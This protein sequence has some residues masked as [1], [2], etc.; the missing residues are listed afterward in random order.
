MA[1]TVPEFFDPRVLKVWDVVG[2][3]PRGTAGSGGFACLS[4]KEL[5]AIYAA[6]PSP[7]SAAETKRNASLATE[8]ART[9]LRRG[10]ELARHMSSDEVARD[11]D[12]LRDAVG[13]ERLNYYGVSYGTLIGARYAEHFPTRVGLMVLDSAVRPDPVDEQDLTQNEVDAYA[14]GD[15]YS[16]D[17]AV[18]DFAES[19]R[20][21]VTCPLGADADAVASSITR[22]L[23]GLSSTPLP[24][25]E[26]SLPRLTEGWAVSAI[27]AGLRDKTLWPD[28]VDAL[29]LAID[30]HDGTELVWMAMDAVGRDDDGTYPEGPV[31]NVFLPVICAD[32][33]VTK[34]DTMRPSPDV[35]SNHPLWARLSLQNFLPCGDWSGPVRPATQYSVDLP[36]PVL[37]IGNQDD[38]TTPIE[39]TE[40]LADLIGGSR[41]VTVEADGH[42][43]YAAGNDC[44][45]DTVH[46]YLVEAKAPE[47]DKTCPA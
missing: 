34:W 47:D 26:D 35:A 4:D 20:A 28:L 22:L 43:A 10:G 9:C 11:L 3:D 41:L 31:G 19:C 16:F 29:D 25:D 46:D 42:G 17:D 44:A 33:P 5:D 36:S 23:D 39:D 38:T 7:D 37:V 45:D 18:D 30:D 27:G 14:R 1:A 12:V 21:S 6:D 8:A 32:W 13:D 2:F 24:T 40:A 15:A